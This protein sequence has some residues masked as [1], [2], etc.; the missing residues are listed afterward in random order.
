MGT[1]SISNDSATYLP[2]TDDRRQL[3]DI[4]EALSGISEEYQRTVDRRFDEM[5]SES[6]FPI[7]MLKVAG[8]PD[9]PL[10]PELADVLLKVADQLARGKA[11]RHT[12]DNSRRCGFPRNITS[13]A[14]KTSRGGHHP[15]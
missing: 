5:T 15:L 3:I 14:D 9:R 12:A 1:R 7:A 8:S 2:N 13:N 10:T 6:D 4:K 11:V